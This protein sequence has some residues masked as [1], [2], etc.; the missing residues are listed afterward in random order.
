VS[1]RTFK[2]GEVVDFVVV[3]SGASGGVMAR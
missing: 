3:G 2:P 1:A